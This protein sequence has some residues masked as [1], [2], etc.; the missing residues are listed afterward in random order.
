MTEEK[1][2]N[3]QPDITKIM[4]AMGNPMLQTVIQQVMKNIQETRQLTEA[5]LKNEAI[6]NQKLDRI[7]KKLDG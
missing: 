5:S 3:K 2:E 1:E 4:Q 6:L 7:L